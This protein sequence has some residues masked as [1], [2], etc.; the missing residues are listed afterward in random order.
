MFLLLVWAVPALAGPAARTPSIQASVA[1]TP[2]MGWNPWNAFHTL[3]DEAKILRNA[4]VLVA[5]GLAGSGY[6]YVVMDDGWWF[7]RESD[8]TIQIRTRMFPSA[9]IGGGRT[10]FRPY[11]DRLHS[12]RTGPAI[13][14]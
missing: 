14:G 6:R 11:V 2:P 10:S 8:G 5:S 7:R 4:E 13:R 1:A 9:D 12:I 3:V